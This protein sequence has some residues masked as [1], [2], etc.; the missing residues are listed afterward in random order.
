MAFLSKSQSYGIAL[1]N[2]IQYSNTNVARAGVL[3]CISTIFSPITTDI[4][5][6]MLVIK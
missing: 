6:G 5:T 4:E 3:K 2:I 1:Y